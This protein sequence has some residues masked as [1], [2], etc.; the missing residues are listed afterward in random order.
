M[1]AKDYKRTILDALGEAL[2]EKGFRKKGAHFSRVLADVV[3][4]A[5]LQSSVSST[6]QM[7]RAT[8][9][10]GVWVPALEG[11]VKPDISSAHWSNRI[12]HLMPENRDVW[13]TVEFDDEATQVAGHIATAVRTFGL[14]ALDGF[15][16]RRAL[17]WIFWRTGASPGLTAFQAERLMNRLAAIVEAG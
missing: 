15:P 6:S 7:L 16:N 9:N 3:H 12:G 13:W 4:L 10:L 11:D 14:P 5:W 1:P 17:L 2:G 8:V